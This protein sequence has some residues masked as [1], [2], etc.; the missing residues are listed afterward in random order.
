[1]SI[2]LNEDGYPHERP[3]FRTVS[4]S[5]YIAMRQSGK[6]CIGAPVYFFFTLGTVNLT[7]A[8]QKLNLDEL[9]R[10]AKRYGLVVK[11]TGAADSATGSTDINDAL[12]E[13]RADFIANEL[14][15]RG[16]PEADIRRKS[17]GG[18]DDFAPDEANRHTKVALYF[19]R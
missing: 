18:I 14:T 3:R 1:M 11:V 16:V 6:R 9:A 8:S 12:S 19:R 7:D 10:V 2:Q 4:D 5:A 13:S 15:S 17:N